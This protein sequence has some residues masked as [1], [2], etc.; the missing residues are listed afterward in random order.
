MR[1]HW[2][3]IPRMCFG[4][5]IIV[6]L[7]GCAQFQKEQMAI[8]ATDYNLVVER[9]QNDVLLLNIVRAAKRRPMYFTTLQDVKGSSSYLLDT[10]NI[11]T[12]IATF[13]LSQ[14]K[15][16]S[17]T[18]AP[19]SISPRANYSSSPIFDMAVLNNSKAFINGML[20]PVTL[21]TFKYFWDQ[22]WSK[23]LL[24]NLFVQ[25]VK[26]PNGK[27]VKWSLR[28]KAN[29]DFEKAL[30]VFESDSCDLE[31]R[32]KTHEIAPPMTVEQLSQQDLV[33]IQ[34]AGLTLARSKENNNQIYYQLK[35]KEEEYFLNCGDD[36][37]YQVT[38]V[39]QMKSDEVRPDDNNLYILHLRSPEGILYLLGEIIRHQ[40]QDPSQEFKIKLCEHSVPLFVA[41][42]EMPSDSDP[43]VR[44]DYDGSK[45]IIP[46]LD[47]DISE[48]KCYA[49]NSMHILSLM[50][51][52]ISKQ[53]SSGELPSSTGTVSIIGGT[54]Q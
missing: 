13:G 51:L 15:S 53:V 19:Y 34:K 5:T 27:T 31:T 10:G 8:S 28:N 52:L 29:E 9:S 41:R 4:I 25:R 3:I 37:V 6:F 21:K 42:K 48:D 33:E 30:E 54:S 43:H 2:Q 44:I 7:A 12:P 18:L 26:L 32:Q 45:Y 11:Y 39:A 49:N 47:T 23:E 35:S 40:M 38:D 50:S 20:T 16:S 1:M 22:G 46:R 24:L 14:I 17:G 36:K